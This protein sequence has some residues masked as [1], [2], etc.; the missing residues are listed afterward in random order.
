MCLWDIQQV[1]HAPDTTLN[2]IDIIV[3][4]DMDFKQRMMKTYAGGRGITWDVDEALYR[5]DVEED[6]HRVAFPEW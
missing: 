5:K 6:P 3:Q 2:H 1:L 4:G